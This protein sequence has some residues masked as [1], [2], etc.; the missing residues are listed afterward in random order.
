[1]G[2]IT[3]F[4]ADGCPHCRRAKAALSRRG[5]PY[6]DIDVDSH[7]N[8][9]AD[10]I[11]LSDRTSVPQVFVNDVHVGGCDETL[12]MLGRWDEEDAGGG[13]L[14]E[15]G[16]DAD[17]DAETTD[18]AIDA[19]T[20]TATATAIAT[21]EEKKKAGRTTALDAYVRL[22]GSKPDPADPRLA[23]PP[24]NRPPPPAARRRSFD[25]DNAR[26]GETFVIGDEEYSSLELIKILVKSMPREGSLRYRGTWYRHAFVGSS[27]VSAL[28]DAFDLGSR[29]D[30]VRLG[31]EL[32]RARYLHHV[33]DER[34][35]GDNSCH[36]VLQPFRRPHVLN[37][38]RAWTTTTAAAAAAAPPL[39]VGDDDAVVV[40][41]ADPMHVVHRLSR[42]W[43]ALESRCRADDDDGGGCFVVDHGPRMRNDELYWRFEEDACE[44]QRVDMAGMDENTRKAFVINVY[45]VM[46]K[47]AFCKVGIPV[48]RLLLSLLLRWMRVSSS[49]TSS[50]FSTE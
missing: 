29:D 21:T 11:A 43:G 25:V 37:S 1:M 50:A 2:R 48:S 35:F 3:V 23:V 41:D 14:E 32:Q 49:Y 17:A 42:L 16:A 12:V 40:D 26:S 46:I 13:G 5:I 22:V 9:R 34:S 33:R 44:L 18:A 4:S 20:A 38:L 8:R 30:A 27:G 19:A 47:Y 7:P 28:R 39:D 24:A 36:F 45:N 6:S 10:M 31:T 15:D